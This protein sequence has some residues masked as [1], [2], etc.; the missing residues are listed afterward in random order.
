LGTTDGRRK[1]GSGTGTGTGTR[2]G[3]IE[4]HLSDRDTQIAKIRDDLERVDPEELPAL[5]GL[6]TRLEEVGKGAKE[7]GDEA[8]ASRAAAAAALIEKVVLAETPDPRAALADAARMLEGSPASLAAGPP[9]AS[10]HAASD[11]PAGA[12]GSSTSPLDRELSGEFIAE[13]LEHLEEADLHLLVLEKDPRYEDALNAVFRAFHTLKGNAGCLGLSSILSLA[14]RAEGLLD[15]AR[16]GQVTLTGDALAAAFEA[17]DA[18][19][20][21]VGGLRE[22][23]A[24]ALAADPS[25]DR[26]LAQIEGLAE[27]SASAADRSPLEP[28]GGGGRAARGAAVED[29]VRVDRDRLDR[30]MDAIGELVVSGSNILHSPHLRALPSPDLAHDLNRLGKAVRKIQELGNSLR[31]VAVRPIFRRLARLARDLSKSLGKPLVFT[32]SG[33]DTELDKA[34]VDRVADPL[35]HMVRNAIDH[36]LEASPDERRRLGKPEAGQVRLSAS[37]RGGKV[38][39][40]IEDDGRGIDS[41][42]VMA[43]ALEK[44]LLKPGDTLDER[45]V[46]D[47]L[48]RPGFSTVRMVTDISGRGVGLD[49]VKKNVESLHGQVEVR[50]RP[51]RGTVFTLKFPLTLAVIDGLMVRVGTQ[52]FV[53][54][55]LSVI[56][57]IRP[58]RDSLASVL[59]KG[60]ILD[61]EDSPVPLIRLRQLLRLPGPAEDPAQ[62]VVVV[63]EDGRRRAGL[64]V[65]ELKGREQIVI[66]SLG[67]DLDGLPGISGGAL[68]PGGQVALILD[69]GGLLSLLEGGSDPDFRR[70]AEEKNRGCELHQPVH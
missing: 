54:P 31:M 10:G 7:A 46:L 59:G 16:K 44:G 19:R 66:K 70:E 67:E 65:D 64:L 22:S 21:M 53:I 61:L 39:I 62:A 17:V 20:K 57:S 69:V 43:S 37:H 8:T 14:H 5:A 9:A 6:H 40:E 38:H 12:T 60:E 15:R 49:V 29:T 42:R 55:T 36:G 58:R 2:T 32:S 52:R 30:L 3:E 25:I 11:G 24:E 41:D 4:I 35:I 27:A 56:R 34:M 47:L 51:G 1:D 18:L 26:L 33:E 68:L 63:V 45:G 13:A 50:T 48:F 28:G 23:P